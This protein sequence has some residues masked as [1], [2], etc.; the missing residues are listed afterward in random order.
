MRQ[1][2]D[3]SSNWARK[4]TERTLDD[5]VVELE[6]Y[7]H[8]R[9]RSLPYTWSSGQVCCLMLA[10]NLCLWLVFTL[11]FW[12][13]FSA[14]PFQGVLDTSEM[15][16]GRLEIVEEEGLQTRLWAQ[17][18]ADKAQL[19]LTVAGEAG[20]L[21]PGLLAEVSSTEA[22][23][24]LRMSGGGVGETSLIMS[25]H[26]AGA[27]LCVGVAAD[28]Q[29]PGDPAGLWNSLPAQPRTL[30]LDGDLVAVDGAL[31]VNQ[32][33]TISPGIVMVG[34][35][36]GTGDYPVATLNVGSESQPALLSVNGGLRTDATMTAR[37]L[38]VT[39]SVQLGAGG[40]GCV[41]GIRSGSQG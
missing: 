21:G 36:A 41:R 35:A 40:A 30:V 19:S 22:A 15:H 32:S 18:A 27:A 8:A 33:L 34:Q 6:Q 11:A 1:D 28:C 20:D 3:L 25:A 24:S 37:G 31:L 29:G 17:G 16:A 14:N 12:A 10:N 13:S 23:S 26:A 7:M 5:R 2:I 39:E 9:S 4:L 38:R